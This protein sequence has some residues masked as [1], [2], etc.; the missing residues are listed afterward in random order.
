MVKV[1]ANQSM[2]QFST[3]A[4]VGRRTEGFHG[5]EQRLQRRWYPKH[6]PDRQAGRQRTWVVRT[7]TDTFTDK[8]IRPKGQILQ[9]K[10]P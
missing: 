2:S 4:S 10:Q 6:Q 1:K 8:H 7:C 3:P 9:Q 5:T